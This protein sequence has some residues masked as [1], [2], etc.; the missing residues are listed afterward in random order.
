MGMYLRFNI[1][2]PSYVDAVK[3]GENVSGTLGRLRD[4]LFCDREES[5][6]LVY[7]EAHTHSPLRLYIGRRAQTSPIWRIVPARI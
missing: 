4:E 5:P 7:C 3:M 1:V 6:G 2:P